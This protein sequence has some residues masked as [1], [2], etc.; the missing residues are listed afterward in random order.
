MDISGRLLVFSPIGKCTKLA[1]LLPIMLVSTILTSGCAMVSAAGPSFRSVDRADGQVVANS[2]IKVMDVTDGLAQRLVETQR[3]ALFSEAFA[4]SAAAELDGEGLLVGKGDQVDITIWEAPPATLFGAGSTD[5]AA[6]SNGLA[7]ETG[8][9]ARQ[10]AL[11]GQV[12][13]GDGTIIVPFVGPVQAA[14]RTTQQIAATIAARLRGKAHEP[15]VIVRIADNAATNVTVVGEVV[16]NLRLPLTAKRE[17]LLDAL[18]AAGGARQPVGKTTIQITRG[19]VVETLPLATIITDPR[20]NIL[21]KPNDVITALFQPY[22]FTALGAIGR[23]SEIDFEGTGLTLAQALGR[24]GGLDDSRANAKGVFIFRLEDKAA[25]GLAN[26]P[27]VRTTPDG[28]VP[29]IFR[30]NLRDPRTFFMAQSFPIRN[31]D[32][33]YVSNAPLADIQKFVN[34]VGSLVLPIASVQNVTR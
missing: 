24:I 3:A 26:D 27:S 29:V 10:T 7:I 16:R 20:Q 17:R 13:G 34:I 11:P 32:V 18:A 25:L 14:G 9:V 15:Q 33:I 4:A 22:S 21:L 23:N 30:I 31:K 12:V 5:I 8:R 1:V 19:D 28:K 6:G 2:G